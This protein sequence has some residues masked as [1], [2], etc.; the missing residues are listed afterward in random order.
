MAGMKPTGDRGDPRNDGEAPDCRG[1]FIPKAFAEG[2]GWIAITAP[3]P[4]ARAA[5]L[6]ITAESQRKEKTSG[7]GDQQ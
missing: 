4:A 2:L 3:Q 7:R 6:S 5:C 1:A